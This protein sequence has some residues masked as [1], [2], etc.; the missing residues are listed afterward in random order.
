MYRFADLKVGAWNQLTCGM[1]LRGRLD[2]SGP[3]PV[4]DRAAPADGVVEWHW[5]KVLNASERRI[6]TNDSAEL[7]DVACSTVSTGTIYISKSVTLLHSH[8]NDKGI[9]ANAQRLLTKPAFKNRNKR[10]YCLVSSW[11]NLQ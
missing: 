5:A 4:I 7:D 2:N 3:N 6:C 1:E 11:T 8:E 9:K 10:Y